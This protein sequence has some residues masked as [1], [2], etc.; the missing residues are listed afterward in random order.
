MTED[1][2]TATLRVGDAERATTVGELSRHYADGRLDLAEFDQRAAAAWSARTRAELAGPLVDLPPAAS[3]PQLAAPRRS[4][5]DVPRDPGVVIHL[6][7]YTAVIAALWVV[8]LLT[9]AGHPWPLYPM[10]GWGSGVAGHVL[11][12]RSCAG[13]KALC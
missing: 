4:R 13:G 2:P 5:P 1:R 3:A 8:W 7:V 12:E 6:A 11:A 9:G 10:L